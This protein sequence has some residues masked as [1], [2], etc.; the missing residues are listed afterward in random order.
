MKNKQIRFKNKQ[1]HKIQR[2]EK[3]NSFPQS[4]DKAARNE[5]PYGFTFYAISVNDHLWLRR[6]H[7]VRIIIQEFLIHVSY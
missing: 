7:T 2:P 5:I 4:Q 3:D 6:V 1:I